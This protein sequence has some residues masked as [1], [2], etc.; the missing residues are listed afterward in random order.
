LL[1]VLLPGETEFYTFNANV[2]MT[3]PN[4]KA[5]VIITDNRVVLEFGPL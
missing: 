5:P 1:L 4:A 3:N 2:T